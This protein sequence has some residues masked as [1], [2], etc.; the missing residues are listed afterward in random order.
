MG[1][2]EVIGEVEERV[3]GTIDGT[4]RPLDGIPFFTVCYPPEEERNAI[5]EFK[6][7]SERF[8]AK[9]MS[10]EV[11]SMEKILKA[12]LIEL[13]VA[14]ESDESVVVKFERSKSR[15]ELKEDLSRYLPQQIAEVLGRKLTNKS[16]DSVAVLIRTGALYPFVRTSSIRA[17]LE[18]RVKCVVI[19]AY[20][21]NT[22][23]EML[24]DSSFKLGGY[25]R[26]EIIYWR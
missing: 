7:L 22:I 20:P 12:A 23:G 15:E 10:S 21:A 18:N 2:N 25:Y 8:V 3:V 13:G 6:Q 26:G 11:I 19:I 1:W 14:G 4:F 24:N 16:R 5:K 17:K 9:G